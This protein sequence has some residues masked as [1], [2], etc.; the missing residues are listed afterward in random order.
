MIAR[1]LW[2][3]GSLIALV[4]IVPA[5]AE[6]APAIGNTPGDVERGEELY[7]LCAQC[8]GESGLGNLEFE[9]PAIAGLEEWYV[10]SQLMKFRQG[11]RGMHAQDLAGLRMRPM[12][13]SLVHEGDVAAVAAFVATLPA[14]RPAPVNVGGDAEKGKAY[15]AVCTTCDGPQAAGMRKQ[16]APSLKN[17]SDWYLLA[18]LKKFKAG[19]RGTD[20][21]D[22]ASLLMRPMAMTL[23]DEQA[24]RDVIAYII[25]LPE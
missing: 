6:N 23:L 22:T 5:V 1:K 19:I 10:E 8:H 14:I 15:Y 9:A 18:Q 13:K 20:P 17:A 12:A 3:K 24:M 21:R 11:L 16:Q 2:I 4:A 25:A 7:Q